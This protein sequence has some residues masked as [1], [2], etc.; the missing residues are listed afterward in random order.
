MPFHPCSQGNPTRPPRKQR[1][2]ASQPSSRLQKGISL[3]S[4]GQRTQILLFSLTSLSV[5]VFQRDLFSHAYFPLPVVTPLRGFSFLKSVFLMSFVLHVWN[6]E[7]FLL[8]LLNSRRGARVRDHLEPW[9][10]VIHHNTVTE[11]VL[12]P[13]KKQVINRVTCPKQ[14]PEA[15]EPSQPSLAF[16]ISPRPA[17]PAPIRFWSCSVFSVWK[18]LILRTHPPFLIFKR[19][20][21]NLWFLIIHI[22]SV[23]FPMVLTRLLSHFALKYFALKCVG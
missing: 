10:E 20:L 1:Y 3:L 12:A 7:P 22:W 2:P 17:L 11:S 9:E 23:Y 19:N 21:T 14:L 8:I 6:E 18:Q 16:W 13:G 4:I 15:P 5:F